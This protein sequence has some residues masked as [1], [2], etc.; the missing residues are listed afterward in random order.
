MKYYFIALSPCSYP[1][2][3]LHIQVAICSAQNGLDL[4]HKEIITNKCPFGPSRLQ[5]EID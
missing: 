5:K 1:G 3:P 4:Q 2:K